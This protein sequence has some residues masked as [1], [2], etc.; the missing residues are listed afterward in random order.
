MPTQEELRATMSKK[1]QEAIEYPDPTVAA[2]RK[3]AIKRWVGVLQDNFMEHIKYFKG[4]KLKFLHNV[5]QD[6]GCWSGVRLDNAALG[7]RFTEEKIEE[8]DNPLRKYEMACSYCVVDKIHPLFQKAFESYKNG[9]SSDEL[10][11]RGNPITDEYIRNSLLGGIRRKGPV[12]DFWIDRESGELKQYDAVEGFDS[13][14]KLKWSE[15]VE[16][17]YNHLKEEDK[18]KKLTEAILALSR[19]QSVEKDAPILDFCVRNIGDKD[20]LLQKLLQKDKGVY[21][22]LAELIES[23]FFDTVHDLVQCWCYKGVSERGD[24]SEKIFS[25]DEYD[26]LLYSLSN[27]MLKNPESSVQARSLIM[28]I[29]KCERFTEYRET[30]VNTS[31]YTVPIKSVL[32]GL[33]INWKREDI[34][35]PDREIE[36]EKILDIISFTK[37]CF[38]EKFEL[39]KEDVC[40]SDREIEKEEILDIISFAKSCFP[41]KFELFK[42][43]MVENLR[44]CGREGMEESINYDD[45]AKELLSELEKTTLPPGGDGP[46]YDLRTRSK[47]HGSKKTTLPVDDSPQSELGT[48]SVSGVSSYKK[49]SIFTLSGN[50]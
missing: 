23:C 8:I 33:I 37:S 6:E 47:A 36:K 10:D 9:F 1:L 7:Q 14:V 28:K 18:E 27:V 30:S 29:W 39:F 13:A 21:S 42:E 26:L 20:T 5:F 49:K 44:L 32:G 38:P 25:Q 24:H 34:C 11:S 43:V 15:G 45:L 12:F 2:G 46:R 31:N 4:D 16:Y 17:F 48:P 35:K 41:E 40:K 19:P 3:S 50:K 22:L